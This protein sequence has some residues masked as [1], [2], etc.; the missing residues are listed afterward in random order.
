MTGHFI[1]NWIEKYWPNR[2][3]HLAKSDDNERV[4]ELEKQLEQF[5]EER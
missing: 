2:A 4:Q 5:I 1:Y 3:K